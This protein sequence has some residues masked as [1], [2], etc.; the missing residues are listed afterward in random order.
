LHLKDWIQEKF[1]HQGQFLVATIT[2]N[3]D[4]VVAFAT[5]L[6]SEVKGKIFR[7]LPL[8]LQTAERSSS[9][10]DLFLT[11]LIC[12]TVIHFNVIY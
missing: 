12:H 4:D 1:N 5:R 2:K 10:Q 3:G 8:P 11:D 6:A 9:Q 7:K